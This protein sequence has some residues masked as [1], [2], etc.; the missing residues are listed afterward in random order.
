M[1][2][3]AARMYSL[4]LFVVYN[5][6]S[7]SEIEMCIRDRVHI[8]RFYAFHAVYLASYILQDEVGSRA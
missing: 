7:F 5:A 2:L 4:L 6:P 3:K 1:T 8:G